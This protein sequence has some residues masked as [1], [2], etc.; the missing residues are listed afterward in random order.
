M[1]NI[2]TKQL[3]NKGLTINDDEWKYNGRTCIIDFYADW[4]MPCRRQHEI[5]SELEKELEGV[6]IY[7]VNVEEEY[8]LAELFSI[9]SLPTIM[10]FGENN[11][12]MTG[13]INKIKIKK[14][15]EKLLASV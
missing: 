6:D 13:F 10:I 12:K 7:K 15:L 11:K 5:L 1:K 3:L 2:T 8:E 9:K 14:E 4:C